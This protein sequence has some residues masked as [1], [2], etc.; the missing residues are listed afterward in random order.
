MTHAS[1]PAN[2]PP[3]TDPFVPFGTSRAAVVRAIG[4]GVGVFAA[5]WVFGLV[6]TTLVRVAASQ[7]EPFAWTWVVTAPGQMTAMAFFSPLT[8]GA[9]ADEFD[10]AVDYT[11]APLVI[12][13]FVLGAVAWISR[14]DE[15]RTP[16]GGRGVLVLGAATGVSFA[17]VTWL[18]A[19]LVKPSDA[20]QDASAASWQ[21]WVLGTVLV[22]GA[23]VLGRRPL[24]DLELVRS[25]P[26]ELF[27]AARAVTVHLAV[28]GA[29]SVPAAMVILVAED[30]SLTI[31]TIPLLLLNGIAYAATLGHLGALS[32]SSDF[33]DELDDF[34]GTVWLFGDGTPRSLFTFLPLAVVAWFVAALVLA[35]R[36]RGTDRGTAGWVCTPL[37][38]AV[39]GGAI[40]LLPRMW[41]SAGGFASSIGPAAWF[42]LVFAG[43]GLAAEAASRSV[44]P[45]VAGRLPQGFASRLAF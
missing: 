45:L 5:S 41:V 11:A 33:F 12:L 31:L 37:V 15:S 18:I 23:C 16:T 43:W 42:I 3:S 44:A 25:W 24:T 32:I 8:F 35:L 30:E 40:C 19:L 39:V 6:L 1:P 38:Y 13:A 10:I 20:G 29:L 4:H 34:S 17:L 9:S 28:F 22:G 36:A 26:A 27:A 7:D 14:R 2:P 21:T